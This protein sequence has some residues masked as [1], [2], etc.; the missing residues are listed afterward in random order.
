MSLLINKNNTTIHFLEG[1]PGSGKNWE[2]ELI[3]NWEA[4]LDQN[5]EDQL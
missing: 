1:L 2:E 3:F 4:W 5:W